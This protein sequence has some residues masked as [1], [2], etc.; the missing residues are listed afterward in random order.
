MLYA[1]N[2]SSAW[3][4]ERQQGAALTSATFSYFSFYFVKT[5]KSSRFSSYWTA[6]AFRQRGTFKIKVRC[7][8]TRTT[9]ALKGG[10]FKTIWRSKLNWSICLKK[11]LYNM[12]WTYNDMFL[13][14]SMYWLWK[15]WKVAVSNRKYTIT[16]DELHFTPDLSDSNQPGTFKLTNHSWKFNAPSL[17]LTF[18][19]QSG[20]CTEKSP[21]CGLSCFL[22]TVGGGWDREG[23]LQMFLDPTAAVPAGQ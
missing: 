20:C 6:V 7:H 17:L 11:Y 22:L 21:V 19:V 5:L 16:L 14:F 3:K 9:V 1:A 2:S 23:K 10:K 15:H 4:N 13:T 18:P 8:S 12:N